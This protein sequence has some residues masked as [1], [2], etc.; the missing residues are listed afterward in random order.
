MTALDRLVWARK[1]YQ[2][3][4][5]QL[6]SARRQAETWRSGL[7]GVTALLGAVLVV[8]GRDGLAGLASPYPPAILAVFALA[9]VILVVA[10]FTA[11]RAASGEPG[12]ELL[13]N[14][15]ELEAWSAAEVRRVHRSIRAARWLTVIGLCAVAS[16]AA[17]AWLAPADT[18]LVRVSS[19]DGDF[20]GKLL[21]LGDGIAK[22]GESASYNVVPLA[23]V[24]RIQEVSSC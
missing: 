13:L 18:P 9:L 14:A 8:K 1:A 12:E 7:T 15:E 2:F 10:T 21:Q 11:V 24:V 4:F 23:S 20:C 5:T 3:K 22:V 16:G 17:T 19:P 6:E